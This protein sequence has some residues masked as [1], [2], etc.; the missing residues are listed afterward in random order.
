M[1]D[2]TAVLEF[3]GIT[4]GYGQSTVLRDLSF[5]VPPGQVV[6][7]LGANGVGKTTMLR[8]AAGLLRPRAGRVI[9]DQREATK[10]APHERVKA[11]ICLIPEGRGIFRSLTVAENLRIHQPRWIHNHDLLDAA[12]DAFPVLANRGNQVAGS[13]SGGEQQMLALARAWLTS[14]RLVM[15]DEASMGLAPRIVDLVFSGLH[16]LAAQGV[17]LLIVEQYV[18]LVLDLADR[19]LVLD[20]SGIRF[21]GKPSDLDADELVQAYLGDRAS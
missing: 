11:G 18:N 5:S 10:A 6:G 12:V 15:V 13:L 7:C 20:K 16:K 17:A 9:V 8:V 2:S 14:P 3:E 19:V 21:S 1:T 4:A